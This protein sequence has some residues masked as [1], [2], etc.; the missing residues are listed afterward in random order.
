MSECICLK[1]ECWGFTCP[2][3]KVKCRAEV[4]RRDEER[5]NMKWMLAILIFSLAA[6]GPGYDWEAKCFAPDGATL[7]VKRGHAASS[8]NIP[9]FHGDPVI[10]FDDNES[11]S[12]DR[13][14]VKVQP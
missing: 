3:H 14:V 9:R 1:P 11:A 12:C 5:N 8:A 6:C 13:G 2:V 10:Y 7:W 4:P